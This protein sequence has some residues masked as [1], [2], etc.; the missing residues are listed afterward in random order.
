[1]KALLIIIVIVAAMVLL[2]WI[3]F[4]WV[5]DRPSV[6]ANPD[7][8]QEDV[9]SAGDVTQEAARKAADQVR[10]TDVDIDV[11]REPANTQ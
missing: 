3:T 10:R 11:D 6:T 5:G 1:M 9:E 2:G 4:S 7:V 8:I